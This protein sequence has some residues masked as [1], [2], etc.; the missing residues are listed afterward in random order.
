M[1]QRNRRKKN[2]I[3]SIRMLNIPSVDIFN[4]ILRYLRT[5]ANWNVRLFMAPA[6]LTPEIIQ[7]AEADGIDGI[8]TNHTTSEDLTDILLNSHIPLVSIGNSDDRLFRRR[9]NVAFVETDNR[10]IGALAARQFAALGKFRTYGFIPD[11]TPTRWSRLRQNGFKNEIA[12]SAGQNVRVFSSSARE[13]H[14]GYRAGLADWLRSLPG[15]IALMVVGDYRAIDVINACSRAKLKIPNDISIISVDNNPILCDSTS[16][17]LSSIEPSFEREGF[18]AAKT[19][20]RMMRKS[21]ET[22]RPEIIRF[23]PVRL[24]ERESTAPTAPAT[25]LIERAL[26]LINASATDGLTPNDIATRLGV[27]PSLLA[28]RFRQLEKRTVQETI[29]NAKLAK[30]RTLIRNNRLT[31]RQIAANCGFSSA[32]YLT[33]LFTARYKISPRAYRCSEATD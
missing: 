27:S 4:G 24:V 3:L 32:S 2:V 30:A 31:L 6:T 26:E 17:A 8:L 23:P 12:K 33:R 1:P 5:K 7:N 28:L 18:E 9:R 14:E 15:P 16:P 20:D 22:I 29:I 11:M 25:Q 10:A 21:T 13:G 19:L